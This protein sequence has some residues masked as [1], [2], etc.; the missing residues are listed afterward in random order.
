MAASA[1]TAVETSRP[2][3]CV[4]IQLARIGDTLQSLMALRAA[5]QL[6]P[7]LEIT[8]VARDRFAEAAKRV[9][10]I[11]NV[12]TFPTDALLGPVLNKTKSE[13][14][15]VSDLARWTIPLVDRQWDL[16]VNWT[17]SEASSYL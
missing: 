15:A 9:S 8:F 2:I 14:D 12:V 11:H 10:W 1:S 13:K 17:F 5:K 3:R 7:Q 6:Y 4:V 16:V